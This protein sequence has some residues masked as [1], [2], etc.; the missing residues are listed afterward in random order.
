MRK[1][2][3]HFSGVPRKHVSGVIF[4]REFSV[5]KKDSSESCLSQV[6]ST[7]VVHN[8]YNLGFCSIYQIP[9]LK[10]NDIY[11]S[12]VLKKKVGYFTKNFQ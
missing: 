2:R 7:V 3:S 4:T 8:D 11:D 12:F 6:F 1:K 5:E 9:V 10:V